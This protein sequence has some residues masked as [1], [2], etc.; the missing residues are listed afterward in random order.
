MF[1]KN[2]SYLLK[3]MVI[4]AIVFISL[5][6]F[7]FFSFSNI[8]VYKDSE[9]PKFNFSKNYLEQKQETYF[10][11][12]SEPMIFGLGGITKIKW[13]VS[14]SKYVKV[15]TDC[16]ISY[17]KYVIQ[18]GYTNPY[19]INCDIDHN[20]C[21]QSC[22]IE[23]KRYTKEELFSKGFDILPDEANPKIKINEK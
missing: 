23:D 6:F 9:F 14:K 8:G 22:G 2:W 13:I 1:W 12:Y 20:L 21:F 15:S 18:N 7:M 10:G 11:I 19:A 3:G 16:F 4:I 17:N 5:A